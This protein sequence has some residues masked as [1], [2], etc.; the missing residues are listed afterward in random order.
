M[1]KIKINFSSQKDSLYEYELRIPKDFNYFVISRYN[2]E[3]ND[4]NT[5]FLIYNGNTVLLYGYYY[6]DNQ[7]IKKYYDEYQDNKVQ[8][9]MVFDLLNSIGINCFSLSLLYKLD[10]EIKYLKRK[11]WKEYYFNEGIKYILKENISND[12][13]ESK[14]YDILDDSNEE[15]KLGEISINYDEDESEITIFPNMTI[16]ISKLYK[17][18]ICE[19]NK[20]RKLN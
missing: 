15:N 13:K 2:K 7:K 17:S 19:F 9:E 18:K 1:D 4:Y 10:F 12:D 3:S 6:K 14:K 11:Y 5:D 20:V 16:N 8:K